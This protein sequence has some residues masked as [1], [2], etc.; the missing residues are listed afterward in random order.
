M[1][2]YLK[3]HKHRHL[4]SYH[5]DRVVDIESSS[6]QEDDPDEIPE[7]S[8]S[9]CDSSDEVMNTKSKN[10]EKEL[11]KFLSKLDECAGE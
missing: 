11:D 5:K 3:T 1:V 10:I 9:S 7:H 8:D 6:H 4:M 2:N